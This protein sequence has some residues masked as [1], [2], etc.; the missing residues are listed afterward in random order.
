MSPPASPRFE[1]IL[2]RHFNQ[3][4]NGA[5]RNTD[6]SCLL[7]VLFKKQILIFLFDSY[8]YAKLWLVW[9]SIAKK[10]YLIIKNIENTH[11]KLLLYHMPL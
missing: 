3:P 7:F 5:A 4:P 8:H 10:Y 6:F 2:H 9:G 1:W 11:K